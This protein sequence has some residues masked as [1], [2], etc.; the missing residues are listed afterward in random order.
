MTKLGE[1]PSPSN[2]HRSRL[3]YQRAGRQL[4]EERQNIA[5]LG[6][7][8]LSLPSKTR[9]ARGAAA[10]TWQEVVLAATVLICGT[11]PSCAFP[12]AT[13]GLLIRG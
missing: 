4:L 7:R 13:P 3:P 12:D 5:T 9:A 11:V 2:A 1:H 8:R 10:M 6:L